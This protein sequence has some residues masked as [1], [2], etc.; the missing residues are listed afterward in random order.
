MQNQNKKKIVI[1]GNAGSGKTT[2][3]CTLQRKLTL[4]L[5]HLD[6]YYWLP[7]WQ[8]IDFAKFQE[9]HDKI[10][11]QEAWIIEGPIYKNTLQQRIALANVVIFLDIPR[12]VCLLR[13]LK[14]S[15]VNW[16]KDMPGSPAD[17]KQQ[18]LSFKSAHFFTW[19][20]RFNKKYKSMISNILDEVKDTKQVYILTSTNDI[21]HFV[22]SLP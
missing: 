18:I 14:R 15:I 13:I 1:V 16:G 21:K 8:R 6:Q 11:L 5:Y 12:Y 10:C 3:A 4:P 7:N 9:A 19:V 2:L 17:C 22:D 20:W